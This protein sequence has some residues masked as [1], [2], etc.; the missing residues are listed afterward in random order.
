MVAAAATAAAA[1][2]R[3]VQLECEPKQFEWPEGM[4]E[5][6]PQ[7]ANFTAAGIASRSRQATSLVEVCFDDWLVFVSNSMYL[8]RGRAGAVHRAEC[9]WLVR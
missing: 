2:S 9:I 6:A 7:A 4:R 8:P 5:R 3:S 1:A